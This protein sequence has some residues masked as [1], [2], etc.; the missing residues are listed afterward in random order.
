MAGI[1][2]VA[3]SDKKLI[4][5]LLA[6]AFVED[7]VIRWMLPDRGK[8][9]LFFQAMLT[10]GHGRDS[11]RD[12][13]M[14]DGTAVG[15]SVWDPPGFAVRKVDEMRGIAGFICALGKRASYGQELDELC[16]EYRPNQPYWYLPLIGATVQGQGVGTSMLHARLDGMAGA[17]H[18]EASNEANVPLYERFGFEV[19]GEIDLPHGGPKLWPMRRPG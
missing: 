6:Q 19:I 8:D 3:S 13:A 10:T 17:V 4:T 15:A 1:S 2:V 9:H 12:V 14:L 7:P 18:L 5:T 11:G 16:A